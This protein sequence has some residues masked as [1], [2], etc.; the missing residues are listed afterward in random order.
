MDALLLLSAMTGDGK[1]ETDVG[2]ERK[3][4]TGGKE[5]VATVQRPAN[6]SLLGG[7]EKIRGLP[8][9]HQLVAAAQHKCQ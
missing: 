8:R 6:F 3:K 1:W 2:G 9:C 7:K 4:R 5:R